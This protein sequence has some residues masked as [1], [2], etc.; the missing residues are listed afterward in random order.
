MKRGGAASEWARDVARICGMG[1]AG[2][3]RRWTGVQ[4]EACLAFL[5]QRIELDVSRFW[6]FCGWPVSAKTS[7]AGAKR[8][9]WLDNWDIL[10]NSVA[11][12]SIL[13]NLKLVR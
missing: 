13:E 11:V 12:K 4:R 7:Q 6:R 2:G 10:A 8:E 9:M 1:R 3:L 5:A